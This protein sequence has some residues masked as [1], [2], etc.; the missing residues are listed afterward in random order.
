MIQH[1]S[2]S[3]LSG[4]FD[5][6]FNIFKTHNTC[7]IYYS[8]ITFPISLEFHIWMPHK[9]HPE[10]LGVLSKIQNSSPSI[11]ETS[12]KAH[13]LNSY[14]N[15]KHFSMALSHSHFRLW[16][17]ERLTHRLIS[18]RYPK[19]DAVPWVEKKFQLQEHFT[20]MAHDSFGHLSIWAW[21]ET[22]Q[23]IAQCWKNASVRV[24]IQLYC[25]PT[26]D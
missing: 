1:E 6:Y 21:M 19:S 5:N 17:H 12:H 2:K 10:N 22:L 24:W 25:E 18:K 8:Y 14:S 16:G 3:W 7:Y 20:L 26:H 15:A 4:C 9:V 11:Y 23:F 13:K